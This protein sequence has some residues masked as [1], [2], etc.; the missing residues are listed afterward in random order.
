MK[1]IIT[2]SVHT[3]KY[4]NIRRQRYNDEKVPI[5]Q[6]KQLRKENKLCHL[7]LDKTGR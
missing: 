6:Q 2:Q 5:L 3:T 7:K 4:E 1:P